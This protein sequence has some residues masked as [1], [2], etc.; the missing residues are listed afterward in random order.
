MI[1]TNTKTHTNDGEIINLTCLQT[2]MATSSLHELHTAEEV[3]D[4][5]FAK[6]VRDNGGPLPGLRGYRCDIRPGFGFAAYKI[7]RKHDIA[8]V[9]VLAWSED[10]EPLAWRS[11]QIA[12]AQLG[13]IPIVFTNSEVGGLIP[14]HA[15]KPE[16]L[17]WLASSLQPGVKH[18]P[19]IDLVD[20]GQVERML[21]AAI[22]SAA[23]HGELHHKIFGSVR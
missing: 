22:L 18:C 17:P 12:A 7:E 14:P 10:A 21:A 3:I 2:N 16:T 19:P 20:L 23:R 1:M 5:R 4:R 15:D 11:S 9:G 6:L 8:V 13:P